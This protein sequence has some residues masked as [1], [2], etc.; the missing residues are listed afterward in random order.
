MEHST[1][2]KLRVE[3]SAQADVNK[4]IWF[5]FRG[6]LKRID[7]RELMSYDIHLKL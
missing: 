7:Y 6:H 5:P 2:S 1:R 3:A 4:C